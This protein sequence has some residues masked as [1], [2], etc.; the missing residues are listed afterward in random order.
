MHENLIRIKAVNQVLQGL[1]HEFVFVGGA[2]V[3]LYATSP[4]V[5]EAVRP[6]DDVDVIVELAG[7]GGYVALDARLREIGFRNDI[8]SGVICRYKIQGITVDVMPTQPEAIGFSNFWY[9]E[10]FQHAVNRRLDDDTS[11]KIFSLPYFIASKWEAFK[12]RGRDYRTSTDFEDLVYVF[13]NADDLE[14]QLKASPR[15]LIAYLR[16]AFAPLLDRD[17]FEEGL[18]SHLSGGYGGID[19]NYIRNRLIDAL[20]I[21][22]KRFRGFTR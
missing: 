11:I 19:P 10:G 20:N 9:P 15:H 14:A 16:D 8:Q 4:E 13:E 1:E 7:Y 18:Y 2:T 22:R 21:P 5:A 6:T 12:G 17:D 3:A